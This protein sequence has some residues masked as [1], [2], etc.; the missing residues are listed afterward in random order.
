[1]NKR[2]KNRDQRKQR[3]GRQ[4]NP[5]WRN[6]SAEVHGKWADK[7]QANVESGADPSALVVPKSEVAFEIG[8]TER[9]HPARESDD[10]R[11]EDHAEDSEHWALGKFGWHGARNL[12]AMLSGED[13]ADLVNPEATGRRPDRA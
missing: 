13:V 7:H 9:D 8:K 4:Q 11:A 12:W 5:S 10:S 3:C 6:Q 2:Q 1:M